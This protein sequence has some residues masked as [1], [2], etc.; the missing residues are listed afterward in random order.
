MKNPMGY[1]GII[2]GSTGVL[3]S[4]ISYELA[5]M[6]FNLIL[7]GRSIEKLKELSDKISEIKK[8]PFLFQGDVTQ[9]EFYENLF[10]VVSLKFTKIDFIIN[11]IGQF[12]GLK[13]F[14]HLSHGE[15]DKL[16]EINI[17]SYWRIL[18]ELE[19]LIRKAKKPK[20]IILSNPE[21]SLGKAYHNIFSI[22]LNARNAMFQ[23]LNQEN[24]NLNFKTYIIEIE[25][26]NSG[27]SSSLS[28]N[29]KFENKKTIEISKILIEKC[30]ES[31][32]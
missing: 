21:I 22:C 25:K 15:W 32:F 10:K 9:K 17:S 19:P 27:M 12:N 8:K 1:N 29:Q 16:V 2:F 4:T 20:L 6:N 11:L 18:K 7:Q 23:T 5:K 31:N 24:K 14:T 26:I 3:G 28:G 30:F 13:P